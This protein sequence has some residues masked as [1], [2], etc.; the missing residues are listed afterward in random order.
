MSEMEVLLSRSASAMASSIKE[1]SCCDGSFP[2]RGEE[3]TAETETPKKDICTVAV[4]QHLLKIE[5]HLRTQP[6]STVCFVS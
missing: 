2:V 6:A 5:E 4:A 3:N 1:P